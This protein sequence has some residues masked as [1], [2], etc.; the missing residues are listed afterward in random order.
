MR[1]FA[2]LLLVASCG[3]ETNPTTPDSGLIN[4]CQ[5][6]LPFDLDGRVGVLGSLAVHISASGIVNAETTAELLILLDLDQT[7]QSINAQAL[8]CDLQIPTIPVIST[9]EPIRFVVDPALVEAIGQITVPTTLDGIST[10]ANLT[11][12]RVTFVIG[13][14]VDASSPLPTADVDGDFTQCDG[15]SC[16][17]TLGMD[18]ACDAEPDAK[19]GA[20]LAAQNV[21][22]IPLTEIYATIR[23][24]FALT[25]KVISS[26]RVEGAVDATL[27]QGI[28]GCAKGATPCSV[29]A[30][31]DLATI[32]AFN[33]T[34]TKSTVEPSTFVGVRIPAT[35]TCAQLR[36][37][38]N[39]LFP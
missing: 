13:A 36:A 5:A 39:T 10:C 38:R 24:S 8:I 3:G 6:G 14:K 17:E 1:I 28:L 29:G 22:V 25:G 23:A 19:P 33:P 30:Q 26:D 31:S 34:I 35:T 7:G 11:S 12:Q 15:D 4:Q 9:Q 2:L 21:P 37:M 20:T 27:E 18:C 32:I 16:A